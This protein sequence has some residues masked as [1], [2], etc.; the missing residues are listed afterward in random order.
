[1]ARKQ[2]QKSSFT[3][4]F[5]FPVNYIISC[6]THQAVTSIAYWMNRGT[7]KKKKNYVNSVTMLIAYSLFIQADGRSVG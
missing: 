6:V 1:M 4:C 2:D 7:K 5:Q 3:F